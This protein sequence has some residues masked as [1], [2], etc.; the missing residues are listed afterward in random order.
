MR[1]IIPALVMAAMMITSCGNSVESKAKDFAEDLKEATLNFDLAKISE[2]QE[3]YEKYKETLSEED[4]ELL[5]K[6]FNEE[7]ESMSKD[8]EKK[9]GKKVEKALGGLGSA[10]EAIDEVSNTD[11]MENIL[12][13]IVE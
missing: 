4:Q 13:T 5:E 9:V 2:L 11:D 1:H 7:M 10:L 3:E 12:D 6:T 8:M